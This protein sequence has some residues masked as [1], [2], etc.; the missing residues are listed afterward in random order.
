MRYFTF[1]LFHNESLTS[2]VSFTCRVSS[3]NLA[4]FQVLSRH[5]WPVA[6]LVNGV[7]LG[8]EVRCEEKRRGFS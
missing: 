2:N 1:F 8:N 6:A 4:S 3:F 7:G 5:T